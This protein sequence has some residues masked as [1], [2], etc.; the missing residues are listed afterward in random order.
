ME[1]RTLQADRPVDLVTTPAGW[2]RWGWL[3]ALSLLVVSN[4]VAN[5]ALPAWSYVPWNLAVAGALL[6]VASRSGLGRRQLG[7]QRWRS[8]LAWGVAAATVVVLVYAVAL[9]VPATRDLFSD[10]RVGVGG[11]ALAY[12]ALV[13]IP[14]GTVVLE[15]VAFRS[16][17]PAFAVRRWGL[18]AGVGLAS[19]L[20]GFWHVLPSLGIVDVNPVAQQAFDGSGGTAL[21][22][23]GAVVATTVAGLV[24]CMLRYGSG[25][26]LAPAIVHTTTNSLGYAL[27][28]LIT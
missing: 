17:L 12:H 22:V 25:S 15:E 20:F 9:A 1:R 14:F 3:V 5:R 21:A 6:V 18:V 13:R 23:I 16:V 28:W 2:T 7:L 8:G 11:W 26:L 4:V 27:A 19:V 24:L 10:R